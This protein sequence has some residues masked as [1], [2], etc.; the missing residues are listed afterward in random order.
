MRSYIF[1][2]IMPYSPV[3]VNW[4]FRGT[5]SGLKSKPSK[6]SAFSRV[7]DCMFLQNVSWPSPDYIALYS[8]SRQNC[9]VPES[10][11]LIWEEKYLSCL[12][13]LV[14]FL[15]CKYLYS[16]S[17]CVCCEVVMLYTNTDTLKL[18]LYL[19]YFFSVEFLNQT[20]HVQQL[21]Q[22]SSTPSTLLAFQ[23]S[24]P[25]PSKWWKG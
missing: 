15:K 18:Y 10:F 21:I 19:I 23:Q 13:P 1:W 8:P 14:Q 17:V 4:C 7:A 16:I 22:N 6:K 3:K 5:S 11:S 2:D 24:S 20:S 9:S 25:A 12:Y